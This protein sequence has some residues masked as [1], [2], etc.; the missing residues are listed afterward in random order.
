MAM[1][2][3]AISYRAMCLCFG[4]FVSFTGYAKTADMAQIWEAIFGPGYTACSLSAIH[5]YQALDA[6]PNSCLTRAVLTTIRISSSK[7]PMPSS[8]VLSVYVGSNLLQILINGVESNHYI[9]EIKEDKK[10]GLVF[11]KSRALSRNDRSLNLYGEATVERCINGKCLIQFLPRTLVDVATDYKNHTAR[12]D[13]YQL[14]NSLW[15][16]KKSRKVYW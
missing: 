4:S 6:M 7:S 8:R 10:V 15:E 13:T 16:L 5:S 9:Q 3:K 12:Y 1:K 11:W 14:L 2:R